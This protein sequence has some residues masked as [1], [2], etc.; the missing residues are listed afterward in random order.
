MLVRVGMSDTW[1]VEGKYVSTC[2]PG[3]MLRVLKRWLEQSTVA[4]SVHKEHRR[5]LRITKLSVGNPAPIWKPHRRILSRSG[6][7]FALPP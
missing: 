3:I 4:I 6:P 7:G 5:A 1:P 2:T